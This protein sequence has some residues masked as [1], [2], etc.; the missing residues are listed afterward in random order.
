MEGGGG[1]SSGACVY[2]GTLRGYVTIR[3]CT[4]N[5]GS[6]IYNTSNATALGKQSSTF[7][8]FYCATALSQLRLCVMY[9]IF[10]MHKKKYHI[11]WI[12]RFV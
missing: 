4:C 2:Y 12:F 7:A 3:T 11:G 1:R 5:Y 10:A 6:V 8:V 9:F